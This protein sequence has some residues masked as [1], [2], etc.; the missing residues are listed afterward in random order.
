MWGSVE[1][2]EVRLFLV[3]AEELHFGRTAVRCGVTQSRVS[4]SLRELEQKLGVVLVHRTSRRVALTTAGARF[5]DAVAPVVGDLDA[6]LEATAQASGRVTEPV[7]LG[8]MAA[9]VVGPEVRA[10]VEAYE[11]ANPES[12]VDIVGLPFR[13][14]FGPLRRGEVEVMVTSLPVEVPGTAHGR[15]LARHPR[16]LAVA[17]DHPLAGRESVSVEDLADHAVGDLELVAP[18]PLVDAMSPPR[19]PT[20]RPIPR[21]PINAGEASTLMLAVA[22]GKVVQPVTEPFAATYAHPDVTFVPI[23]DLPPARAVLAWT[24]RSRHPGLRALLRAADEV[25][26]R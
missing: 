1:L 5:R 14:R 19:T 20:G 21:V 2:R 25:A 11:R 23:H 16:M 17:R 12:A 6:V 22:A 24:A 18:R 9:A 7:R 10:I 15:V 26:A 8:V 4:Q 3:L 13:D